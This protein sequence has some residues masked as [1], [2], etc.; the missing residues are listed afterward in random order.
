VFEDEANTIVPA[1]SLYLD[2]I[3]DCNLIFFSSDL[4]FSSPLFSLPGGDR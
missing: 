4:R 2:A 1:T 3:Y